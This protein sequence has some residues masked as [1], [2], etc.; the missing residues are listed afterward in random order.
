M[1]QSRADK[2]Y[3]VGYLQRQV[4]KLEP[5][6]NDKSSRFFYHNHN[7]SNKIEHYKRVIKK[8]TLELEVENL[9]CKY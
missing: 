8:L 6:Y 3:E 7:T 4:K 5:L 9:K 2:I 1:A